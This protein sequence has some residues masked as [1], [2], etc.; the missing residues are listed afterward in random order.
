[1]LVVVLATVPDCRFG[2][3]S[4]LE[5]NCRQIGGLGC[6]HTQTVNSCM[7]R[8]KSP[9]QSKLGGVSVD[10]PAGLSVDSYNALAFAV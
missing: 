10:C 3:G 5:P 4:G 6:Q 8:S 1:M 2:S 7:V 9:N